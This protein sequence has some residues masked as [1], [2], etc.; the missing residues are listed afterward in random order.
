M[1]EFL[2]GRKR[3]C[4]RSVTANEWCP[5]RLQDHKVCV[6]GDMD[7]ISEAWAPIRPPVV[8]ED[9]AAYMRTS[10]AD[11]EALAELGTPFVGVRSAGLMIGQDGPKVIE[12]NARFG[13]L[14]RKWFS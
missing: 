10:C 3:P 4:W 14:R 11:C 2:T 6:N 13:D 8:D 5:W 1:E 7:R 12:F 9:S